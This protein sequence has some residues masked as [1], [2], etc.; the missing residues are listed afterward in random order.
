MASSRAW[1]RL[2][3][4][5]VSY[6]F[7]LP[8]L[9]SAADT[10]G[11][12]SSVVY[13]PNAAA[14]QREPLE[15]GENPQTFPIGE[16][17]P[18]QKRPTRKVEQ[19]GQLNG[20]GCNSQRRR[21]APRLCSATALPA[22]RSTA[23]AGTGPRRFAI[24]QIT[25]L[26]RG[27]H[28]RHAQQPIEPLAATRRADRRFIAAHQKLELIAALRASVFVKWHGEEGGRKRS[29]ACPE[30][31]NYR[32]RIL[33]PTESLAGAVGSY[34]SGVGAT[35]T[36]EHFYFTCSSALWAAASLSVVT[37]ARPPDRRWLLSRTTCAGR[38]VPIQR[39]VAILTRLTVRTRTP[40][41]R[42]IPSP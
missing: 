34:S 38:P 5:N 15:D 10:G 39:R 4:G 40:M 26:P 28:R 21:N 31:G 17:L 6:F 36:G 1:N 11:K 22:P 23:S 32:R 24:R 30:A 9:P 35:S 20:P 18:D 25:R 33:S 7:K 14:A 19:V 41:L 37:V 2:K 29:N 3:S 16:N 8:N 42:V 13:R 27:M 12:S